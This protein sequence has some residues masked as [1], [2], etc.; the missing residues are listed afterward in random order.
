MRPKA[1]TTGTA[2]S[3]PA[4]LC[5]TRWRITRRTISAPSISSPCTTAERNSTGPAFSP[6]MTWTGSVSGV[7][8]ESALTGRSTVL[9]SPGASDVVP[10]R[11]GLAL[12]RSSLAFRLGAPGAGLR[13][14]E[15]DDRGGDIDAGR[16][17]DAF[18]TRRGVDF[19]HEGTTS[20]LQHVDAAD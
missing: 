6:W 5:T 10:R 9:R 4:R 12:M 8:L 18:E 1:L 14:E 7:W 3:V 16:L 15:L 11:N 17:L 2:S 13:L 20:R 19:H